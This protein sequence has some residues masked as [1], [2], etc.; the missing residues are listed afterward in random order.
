MSQNYS[1]CEY[2]GF[3]EDFTVGF[4]SGALVGSVKNMANDHMNS[5]EKIEEGFK[6]AVQGGIAASAISYGGHSMSNGNYVNSLL[7]LGMGAFG[8][9]TI[10]K[11]SNKKYKEIK[12]AKK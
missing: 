9:Y 10:Q 11:I 12:N 5:N 8:V 3:V 4:V 7:A 6:T 2:K 1:L